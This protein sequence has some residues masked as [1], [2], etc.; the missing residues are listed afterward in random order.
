MALNLNELA[1]T[2][3]APRQVEK[4]D[5]L[6]FWKRDLLSSGFGDKVKQRFYSEMHILLTSGLD[7][8]S[9]LEIV[10]EDFAST[11]HY[12]YFDALRKEV[13]R[14]KS[15]AEAQEQSGKFS[16][17]EFY[18][19]RIGEET[20]ELNHVFADLASYYKQKTEQ[21][22]KLINALSYPV[23]VLLTAFGAVFFMLKFIVPL[24]E[25][26]FQR[27][28]KELPELTQW[29]LALS[30]AMG[31]VALI[32]G[33]V[34]TSI[35]LLNRS[36]GHQEQ[37]RKFR[38]HLLMNLPLVGPMVRKT[39]LL[40]FCRA[41]TLLLSSKTPLSEALLLLEKMIRFYPLEQAIQTANKDILQG[42]PLYKSLEKSSLF[43]RRTIT[44]LK[45]GEEVNRLEQ[46]FEQ[47]TEQL[48]QDMEHRA[49]T[50]SSVLEPILILFIGSIVA[51]IL[52]AMYLPMFE[53]SNA[54]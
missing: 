25:D 30:D 9:A 19:V 34:V 53:L 21:K 29:V 14:G 36:L 35:I 11:K 54:F 22:K 47:L 13:I 23:I 40:R 12:P 48:N 46:I 31:P 39:Y 45:V 16:E 32:I 5:A 44:L 51:V 2:S 17:Y 52:I 3:V 18:S 24:F 20:G 43:D 6:P 42:T 10:L 38:S 27:F 4:S 49:A 26:V 28:G 50:L 41:M 8:K 1:S 15:I 37:F 7:V 33:L